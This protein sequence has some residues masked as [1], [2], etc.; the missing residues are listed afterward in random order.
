MTVS[1]KTGLM[2]VFQN[3]PP[4]SSLSLTLGRF[5]A[6]GIL[7]CS[8][9]G[10]L[11]AQTQR[12]SFDYIGIEQGMPSEGAF[13]LLQDKQGYIWMATLNGLV[14]YDGYNYQTFRGSSE[15]SISI[16]PSGRGFVSLL[17]SKDGSIWAASLTNGLTRYLP[18]QEVFENIAGSKDSLGNIIFPRHELLLE[19]SKNRIWM[20]GINPSVRQVRFR[21]YNPSSKEMLT[22]EVEPRSG[23]RLLTDGYVVEDQ[24]GG[25][26]IHD[27]ANTHIYKYNEDHKELELWLTCED[28]KG[29]NG[30]CKQ[31]NHLMVDRSNLLWIATDN[32]LH[33]Y[34]LAKKS[35]EKDH[36]L[37]QL[38]PS[39]K[40]NPVFYAYEDMEGSLWLHLEKK[41][42]IRYNP[43][44]QNHQEHLFDEAPFNALGEQ[45]KNYLYKPVIEGNDG[46]WF[47]NDLKSFSIFNRSFFKYKPKDNSFTSYGENF[48]QAQNK[49]NEI[50]SAFLRDSAGIIWISNIGAGINKQNPVSQRI[51]RWIHLED[52]PYSLGSDT[53][54]N[55]REDK[56][57]DI[58]VMG[59]NMIQK[60]DSKELTFN[61]V[62]PTP[63]TDAKFNTFIQAEDQAYWLGSN[64]GLFWMDPAAEKLK[65][66]LPHIKN[67]ETG[68]EPVLIDEK[69]KLWIKFIKKALGKEYGFALGIYDPQKRRLIKRFDHDPNDSTSLVSTLIKEVYQDK[70]GRIWVSSFAGLCRYQAESNNFIQYLEDPGDSTAISSNFISFIFEDSKENIWVGSFTKGLNKYDESTGGFQK[71][72]DSNT[73]PVVLSALEDRSGQLWFGTERG[74]GLFAMSQDLQLDTFF[75]S[76]STLASDLVAKMVEDENGHLWIPSEV[77]ITRFDPAGNESKIFDENDGFGSYGL[78]DASQYARIIKS[79]AGDIW[80]C[81]YDKLY[82]IKPD[83]L[84][85][86][87]GSPPIVHINSLKVGDQSYQVSDGQ[88]LK[89]HISQTTAIELEH[90]QNDLTFSFI[91]LHYALPS[92][93]LYSYKLEGLDTEW[94]EASK[95]RK[96]RYAGLAPGNYT[97]KIRASSADGKW[98]EA[99]TDLNIQIMKAWWETPVA[100][101]AYFLI[102]CALVYVLVKWMTRKQE[103]K[104]RIQE[105]ELE[106]EKEMTERLKA[107]DLLKDQFLANTS[108]E[109]RTPLNGIIGLSEGVYDRTQNLGDKEDL[110]LIISSGKRLHY[111][112]DDLL[113]FS[114]LKKG[115]F[116]IHK[117]PIN[118]KSVVDLICRMSKP[119]V[120]QKKL[121]LINDI[122]ENIP[123]VMAD[124][125]RIQQVLYNLIGNAIKFTENGGIRI[126]SEKQSDMIK[127]NIMDTGIGVPEDK[128]VN[129]FKEFQQGDGST[130]RKFG[131]TGLGLTIT[132]QLVELHGGQIG[133][134]ST[135][136]KGS[137]FWF[138][139]ESSE[140]EGETAHTDHGKLVGLNPTVVNGNFSGQ[141]NEETAVKENFQ[142]LSTPT[143]IG[144]GGKVRILIVDD[145]PVNQRVMKSHL[146]GDK[147]EL[148]F[149][150]DGASALKI[151]D[152]SPMFDLVLLDVM[153]PNMS[154]YEVCKKIRER[155]LPSELPVIMV[156]AKNQVS[157]LVSG[158]NRGA[159]DYLAKPFTKQEFM[160]RVKTQIDLHNIF[161]IT[162][163]YI[164]NEFIRTLGHDRITDVSLGDLV[165]K[166]VS[167]LF[168]DIR[169]YTSLSESMSPED[170][171]K[172]ISGYTRRMGPVIQENR[173]FVNQYLGDG[174]MAIFKYCVDDAL[175]AMIGMQ[176]RLKEYNVERLAKG[177][178]EIAVGMGLHT[179]PLI[180]GIIGDHQRR[181]AAT[182]SDT[183]NTAARMEGLTKK[184][185]VKILITGQSYQAIINKEKYHFRYLGKITVKGKKQLLDAYE[186]FTGES[187]ER[188]SAKLEVMTLF[189][190]MVDHYMK[191]RFNEALQYTEKILEI[192]PWDS[193]AQYYHSLSLEKNKAK[194]K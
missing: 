4:K 144:N 84:L 149:A 139:L 44:T 132:K 112:V 177:R 164:P 8:I 39:L 96:A 3:E 33:I 119:I 169:S 29:S 191:K 78:D 107:L 163:R 92:E 110:E 153:M 95:N 27:A 24:N 109:L 23:Q 9:I 114:K 154:G 99:S 162:D 120:D 2:F 102:L 138:T 22:F 81:A 49:P 93:N 183:V 42:L 111:L 26:W 113:D 37:F 186:C 17:S 20:Y 124:M 15:D 64:K 72:Y 91:S 147:F 55:I 79:K 100:L 47:V 76:R 143:V 157:D 10:P 155:Y 121:Y 194:S 106:K 108:H 159:N 116:D 11:I 58:W 60:F 156:T 141:P 185:G 77:G 166:V 97:F 122:P 86:N 16:N 21:C 18:D 133:V 170:T 105:A 87:A 14:K 50:P 151:L 1:D 129:I 48:K 145:E 127:V 28:L 180:M 123:A 74:E 90:N 176:T 13:D 54:Y 184:F 150:D 36:R 41:S 148:A 80:L 125:H 71:W 140:E 104:I 126:F 46:I 115:E 6:L 101:G 167:V 65:L 43:T 174:I 94:S 85:S 40:G 75:N 62:F 131:G 171:F 130:A 190:K 51:D 178:P 34:N 68:V 88:L 67:G 69:G 181:D 56:R 173:G 179:G 118:L 30:P 135:L 158:L 52:N 59:K 89:Q 142:A 152:N 182:I 146:Y 188:I 193:V 38:T 165:E 98:T 70:K 12:L 134:E 32:G 172:F 192:N 66:V 83:R 73:F 187:E 161:N 82:R 25:I 31:I 61:S 7:V 137:T 168:T 19:D 189:E 175:D 57:G 45:S 53:I 5:L 117:V 128:L 35:F 136:G 103:E 160:A 63:Y